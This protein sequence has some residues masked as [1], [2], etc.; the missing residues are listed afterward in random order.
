[1]SYPVPHEATIADGSNTFSL[2]AIHLDE[3]FNRN[4][5][6]RRLINRLLHSL[7]AFTTLPSPPDFSLLLNPIFSP[8][9]GV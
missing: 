2:D 1:M 5:V 4:C 7:R 9:V 6:P 8:L 3:E